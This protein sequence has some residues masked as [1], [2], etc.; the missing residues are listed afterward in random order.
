MGIIVKH[1]KTPCSKNCGWD[2]SPQI[3]LRRKIMAKKDKEVDKLI[4][5]MKKGKP[6]NKKDEKLVNDLN[7]T[8]KDIGCG[9]YEL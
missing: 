2:K 1:L 7:E 3:L 9:R 6:L 4:T 8:L 5:K